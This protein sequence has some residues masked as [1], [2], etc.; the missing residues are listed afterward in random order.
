MPRV[1]NRYLYG[2][3]LDMLLA[4]E[5]YWD[6]S[7]GYA[8]GASALPPAVTVAGNTLWALGDHFGS[9]RDVMDNSGVIR[10]HLV[11]DSFGRRVSEQDFNSTGQPISSLDPAAVD[12]LF[13]Y[14]GR[15]WDKEVQLQYNRARWY[16]PATGRWLSQDPIGFEAGDANL[17]RYVGNGPTGA[18]DPSGL[19]E[20]IVGDHTFIGKGHHKIPVSVIRQHLSLDEGLGTHIFSGAKC[21]RLN[22]R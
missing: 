8:P 6:N 3:A 4:D 19:D 12:E 20:R 15:E 9:V 2:H 13:G 22:L 14:T 5:Q 21:F 7:T 17:Y 16:D 1:S 18:T 11:F 10:Q